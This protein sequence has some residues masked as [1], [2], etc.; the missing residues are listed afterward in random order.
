MNPI[1]TEN[2]LLRIHKSSCLQKETWW[3]CWHSAL[4]TSLTIM[5]RATPSTADKSRQFL[6]QISWPMIT[7]QT[8][9]ATRSVAKS[10]S[11][12]DIWCGDPVTTRHSTRRAQERA[13]NAA[14]R[15]I[16]GAPLIAM[17]ERWPLDDQRIPLRNWAKP[18]NDRL[19]S[20]WC[21][22]DTRSTR[23]CSNTSSVIFGTFASDFIHSPTI[24]LS[25]HSLSSCGAYVVAIAVKFFKVFN[26]KY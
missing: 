17:I 20:L 7:W 2:C 10:R 6:R 26:N 11:S 19:I 25:N 21:M 3:Q 5:L 12:H 9:E 16:P 24:L 14:V 18:T 15:S 22:C 4:M 23:F 8:P 1:S 13:G